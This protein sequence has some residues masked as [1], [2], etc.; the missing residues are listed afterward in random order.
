MD[1][2]T[3][4]QLQLHENNAK[5][6]ERKLLF[7]QETFCKKMD[8]RILLE[9][10]TSIKCKEGL[11]LLESFEI[12]KRNQSLLIRSLQYG[13]EHLSNKKTIDNSPFFFQLLHDHLPDFSAAKMFFL[14]DQHIME[15]SK[16]NLLNILQIYRVLPRKV[17]KNRNFLQHQNAHWE[18]AKD[19]EGFNQ[20]MYHYGSAADSENFLRSI[21][22]TFELK[23]E[24]NQRFYL[25][26]DPY[27]ALQ[28]DEVR[29]GIKRT[30]S[31]SIDENSY[32]NS[33]ETCLLSNSDGEH[34]FVFCDVDLKPKETNIIHLDQ[35]PSRYVFPIQHVEK[36]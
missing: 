32:E 26:S 13:N 9:H 3:E 21:T 22:E 5:A 20:K 7:I 4:E 14:R 29:G 33:N 30:E 12:N 31:N 19:S 35:A 18:N 23:I 8:E 17:G 24:E 16:N 10:T 6:L 1:N 25:F 2:R 15:D 11:N 36:Y 28:M 27:L 34:M